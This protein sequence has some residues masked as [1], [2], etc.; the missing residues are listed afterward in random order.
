MG[1]IEE[2]RQLIQDFVTPEIRS[3]RRSAYRH[4]KA[5]RSLDAKVDKRF[6]SIEKR[7][8]K[9]FDAQNWKPRSTRSKI[10]SGSGVGHAAQDGKLHTCLERLARLESN[11]KTL[12]S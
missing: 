4:R 12:R 3:H 9:K 8:D 2:G 5:G 7:F 6:D 11:F 10:E 1:F